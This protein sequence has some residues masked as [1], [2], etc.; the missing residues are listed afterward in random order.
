MAVSKV[1]R[2]CFSS[3]D[4]FAPKRAVILSKLTRYSY[5]KLRYSDL[6]EGEFKAHVRQSL[7]F[8]YYS[9]PLLKG[10]LQVVS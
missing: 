3:S 4:V 5:E 2:R 6:D 8:F 9:M 7:C 1:F 10:K